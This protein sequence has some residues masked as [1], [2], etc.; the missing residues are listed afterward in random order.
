[1]KIKIF[2]FAIISRGWIIYQILQNIANNRKIRSRNSEIRWVD[3][4]KIYQTE[5]IVCRGRAEDNA[6]ISRKFVVPSA[7]GSAWRKSITGKRAQQACFSRFLFLG[8]WHTVCARGCDYLRANA[9]SCMRDRVYFGVEC[10]AREDRKKN[11]RERLSDGWREDLV[12][13]KEMAE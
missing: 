3:I 10:V 7:F 4:F 2:L 1:M 9:C 11:L 13:P 6:R 12:I 5:T 8:S